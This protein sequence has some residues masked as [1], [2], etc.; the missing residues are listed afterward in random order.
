MKYHEINKYFQI[1]VLSVSLLFVHILQGNCYDENEKAYPE[2]IK[3]RSILDD[4]IKQNNWEDAH[5][6][7]RQADSSLMRLENFLADYRSYLSGRTRQ[8]NLL[9]DNNLKLLF[10]KG[11]VQLNNAQFKEAVK[12]FRKILYYDRYFPDANELLEEAQ[13]KMNGSIKTVVVTS[14][15]IDKN[16]TGIRIYQPDKCYKGYTLFTHQS[17]Y[18]SPV[19][20]NYIYLIDMNGE[21]IHKWITEHVTTFARLSSEGNLI[22][23]GGDGLIELDPQSNE[24]WSYPEFIDHDFHFLNNEESLLFE[25]TEHSEETINPRIEIMD[26]NKNIIWQ[27]K[28]EDHTEELE[29][30]LGLKITPL[31]GDWAHINTCSFLGDNELETKDRRFKKDN[32]IFSYDALSTIGIIDYPSGDIVWAWGPGILSCPHEPVLLENGE[33]IIFDNGTIH[34]WSR[35]IKIN[36]LTEEIVWEYHADPKEDFFSGV[37]SNAQQLPNGNILICEAES[38]RIFEI[39]SEGEIVWD[40][41]STF[42]KLTD[43]NMIYRAYRYSPEYVKP[44]LDKIKNRQNDNNN[45]LTQ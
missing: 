34:S 20:L 33:F 38:N 7:L 26:K 31:F 19:N 44:L 29:N 21:I 16:Q 32:I 35:I 17:L 14:N 27:W 42:G 24:I 1:S 3:Y 12:T 5:R 39:T 28:G 36:P 40:F 4:S 41:I 9:V 10:A 25:R 15:T 23:A 2:L 18:T 8:T 43:S 6:L 22:F 37:Q 13:A 45:I 11:Q 30:M